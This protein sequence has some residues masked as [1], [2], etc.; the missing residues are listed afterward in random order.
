MLEAVQGTPRDRQEVEVVDRIIRRNHVGDPEVEREP[1]PWIE[2][3]AG[4]DAREAAVAVRTVN[5]V[6]L[7]VSVLHAPEVRV[8]V[9][10]ADQ[11]VGLD[12]PGRQIEA[13]IRADD[14]HL[15]SAVLGAEVDVEVRQPLA[16][17]LGRE[18]RERAVAYA[19]VEPDGIL[20]VDVVR[21]LELL[22]APGSCEPEVEARPVRVLVGV[23]R[24]LSP[25]FLFLILLLRLPLIL[26]LHVGALVVVVALRED[27]PGWPQRQDGKGSA[28]EASH[29][30][31]SGPGSASLHRA[32]AAMQDKPRRESA[33]ACHGPDVGSGFESISPRSEAAIA[34]PRGPAPSR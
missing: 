32:R 20:G 34:A 9:S 13:Q 15:D 14:M 25:L 18:P 3:H 16:L 17:Q 27:G 24:Q 26:L 19:R 31:S 12:Q 7:D 8:H 11:A 10:A 29:R 33:L 4:A 2:L 23:T 5:E 28:D 22:D 1:G 21:V 30:G 6:L